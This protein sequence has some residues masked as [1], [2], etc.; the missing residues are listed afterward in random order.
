[1]LKLDLANMPEFWDDNSD[2]DTSYYMGASFESDSG[3]IDGIEVSSEGKGIRVSVFD[4]K[5]IALNALENRN[6]FVVCIFQP[7]TTDEISGEWWFSDCIPNI[8]SIIKWNTIIE[9]YYGNCEF[10]EIKNILY[11]TGNEIAERVHNLSD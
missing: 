6:K 11:N 7:G 4:T 3:F 8:V 10:D 9:V 2:L 1:M 5:E